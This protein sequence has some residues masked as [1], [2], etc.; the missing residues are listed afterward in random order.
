MAYT[1]YWSQTL[2]RT[3]LEAPAKHTLSIAELRDK[4]Y[5]A[6]DD[7]IGTLQMMDVLEHKKRG[8][9]QALINKSKVRTWAE[10][11]KVN[12]KNP[13]DPEA[14]ILESSEE[15]EDEEDEEEEEDEDE[16]EEAEEDEEMEG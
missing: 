12:L 2:A 3:I 10:K 6:A 5:I 13:I 8:G 16:E 15:D 1:H 9:A 11:N 4:T 7:I 14:F